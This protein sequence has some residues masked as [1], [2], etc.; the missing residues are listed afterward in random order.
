MIN[1]EKET[2]LEGFILKHA[3]EAIFKGWSE[4]YSDG[5]KSK[6]SL[7]FVVVRYDHFWDYP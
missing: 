7:Y 1:I 4:K 3:K 2:H 6:V 5:L